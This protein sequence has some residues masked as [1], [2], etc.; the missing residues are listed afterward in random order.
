V[1][2][3]NCLCTGMERF[4]GLTRRE[5]LGKLGTGLGTAALSALLAGERA[6]AAPARAAQ[7]RSFPARAKR[8]ISLFQS[9]APSQLD[10]FDYKPLLNQRNGEDLPES[11]RGGQR[12]TGMTA[13]QAR[14]PLAGSQFE[15][16]QH[17]DSGAWVSDLLPHTARVADDLCFVKSMFTDAIN[18]DPGITFLQ[19]GSELPGRPSLG[20]WLGYGLGSAN[21]DLPTFVVLISRDQGGQP[22][23]GRLWGSGFL[24]ASHQG[25][26]FR[27]GK[28]P[29]LFLNNPAGVSRKSRRILLDRLRDLHE[30]A[31]AES[32]D[33]AVATRITQFEMAFR[34]Q[35]S[36]P[37]VTDLSDEPASTFEAYGPDSR[38]PGTFAANC[39]LA[40]RLAERG[41]M[42][43][44]LFHRGWDQHGDL[45]KHIRRQCRATDQPAA[46]LVRDLKQRG[47]L[48]DTLVFWG[49]EFGRSSFSQGVLTKDNYGRDHHPKCFT[50]WMAG[51]GV[52]A[53]QSYGETDE[54]GYN[55]AR[56][57]VHVHDLH[58]TMLHLLGIDHERLTYRFQGRDFRLTDVAGEVIKKL[59]V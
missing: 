48:D 6:T 30:C 12:L 40:R 38:K 49:G 39:I 23:Y 35:T 47:L 50:V 43:V 31:L 53:G 4:T 54:F 55:I 24:P 16:A 1:T 17:G 52:R 11:V 42:C 22:V 28:D 32:G 3:R 7:G 25:V 44:Q 10:L 56:D 26:R 59:I 2:E 51:G 19:T 18:H 45:P 34:M 8:V 46:A 13:H 58:A 5:I 14:W 21:E 27:A 41:V 29:I 33:A 15:F 36:V 9:G 37:E 20:A 57:G